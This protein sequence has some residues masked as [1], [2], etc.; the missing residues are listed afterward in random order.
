MNEVA[1][2]KVLAFAA[3]GDDDRLRAAEIQIGPAIE[4]FL[5]N[6]LAAAARL[7]GALSDY[8][9]HE[10]RVADG[11]VL[12]ERVADATI[13]EAARDPR[14]AATVAGALV[15]AAELA[16]R[17]GDDAA[18]AKRARDAIR[19]ATLIEDRTTAARARDV[20]ARVE[21]RAR[22]ETVGEKPGGGGSLVNAG[23]AGFESLLDAP[24]PAT[25]TTFR[26]NG[27]IAATPVW[28]RY[29]DGAFE[30]VIVEGDAKLANLRRDPRFLLMI[31]EVAPPFR[32]VEVSGTAQ[33]RD[34][35]DVTEARADISGRYLGSDEGRRFA[36]ERRDKPAALVRLA[37]KTR[38][39]DMKGLLETGRP[40]E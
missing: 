33:I 25:L 4:W 37:G 27:G 13:A 35:L 40:R 16:F 26:A 2:W 9:Q 32:R 21:G 28:F 36:D 19:A 24:S 11:R 30:V 3:S 18:A 5:E 29:R 14:I 6:D 17:E 7:A 38:T 39:W 22:G 1:A 31:F 23:L 20:L 34:G 10:G 8:W 15:A 12:A